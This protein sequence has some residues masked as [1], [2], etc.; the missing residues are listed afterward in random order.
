MSPSLATVGPS[1]QSIWTLGCG[2]SSGFV[3]SCAHPRIAMLDAST[4]SAINT[5]PAALRGFKKLTVLRLLLFIS[6][7]PSKGVYF[8]GGCLC[9]LSKRIPLFLGILLLGDLGPAL[10]TGIRWMAT[11]FQLRSEE[12]TSELQSRFG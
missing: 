3:G 1:C 11:D 8:G 5:R 6:T 2:F 4:I 12:H 10:L 7:F 9:W